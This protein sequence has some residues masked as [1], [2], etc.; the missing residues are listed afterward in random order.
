MFFGHTGGTVLRKSTIWQQCVFYALGSGKTSAEA[1][2]C[3]SDCV[4]AHE[5]LYGA[6]IEAEEEKA[7][8]AAHNMEDL[9]GLPPHMRS[10][11]GSGRKISSV[12]APASITPIRPKDGDSA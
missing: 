11:R 9:I 10:H 3:A 4:A 7:M 8:Q 6:A 1:I 2:A 12:D 5:E